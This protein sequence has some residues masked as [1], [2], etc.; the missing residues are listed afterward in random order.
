MESCT[1]RIR[2][3]V[4]KLGIGAGKVISFFYINRKA[5]QSNYRG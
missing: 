1:Y 5:E 4:L 2:A 3:R